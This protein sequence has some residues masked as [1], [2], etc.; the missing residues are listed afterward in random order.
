M[1]I[2][3]RA[4]WVTAILLLFIAVWAP[5]N[6][7]S[8]FC[9]T[10]AAVLAVA[11]ILLPRITPRERPHT[12]AHSGA[13]DDGALREPEPRPLRPPAVA[14]PDEA[15]RSIP[16]PGAA[17]DAR[18]AR[19]QVTMES[20]LFRLTAIEAAQAAMLSRFPPVRRTEEEAIGAA[21]L[22]RQADQARADS[23][24]CGQETA[25]PDTTLLTTTAEGD[26]PSALPGESMPL[27]GP[28]SRA[29]ERQPGQRSLALASPV[30]D[31]D[32]TLSLDALKT[33]RDAAY[34]VLCERKTWTESA[35]TAGVEA[36]LAP[37]LSALVRARALRVC[38]HS[39]TGALPPD[40]TSPDF[41]SVTDRSGDGWLLP[42]AGG[43]YRYTFV[44]QFDGDEGRWPG[45]TLAAECRLDQQGKVSILRRGEL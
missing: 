33:L 11:V 30:A 18:L 19:L 29:E 23:V 10:I 39:G 14:S 44:N 43:R 35:L 32:E 22:T 41:I 5:D 31:A 21:T 27:A 6:V 40:F 4:G 3:V 45:F 2:M 26:N 16:S 17:P 42:H 38:A 7:V 15:G 20:I 37:A 36:R 1:N 12:A 8:F 9:A 24:L 25:S 34:V 28:S 13:R